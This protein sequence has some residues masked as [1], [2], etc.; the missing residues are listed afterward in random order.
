LQNSNKEN[1]G[2]EDLKPFSWAHLFKINV[3]SQNLIGCVRIGS[4]SR[5]WEITGTLKNLLFELASSP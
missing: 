3:K 1:K 5:I 2:L 4:W